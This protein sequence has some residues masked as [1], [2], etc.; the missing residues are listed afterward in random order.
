MRLKDYQERALNALDNWRRELK[1]MRGGVHDLADVAE[2]RGR[3][4]AEMRQ[5]LDFPELAWRSMAKRGELPGGIFR[6]SE[7]IV[8]PYSPRPNACGDP[9]P[10]VCLKIPTGGGKTFLG[11]K[12]LE[13][14]GAMTGVV[15]WVTPS[16]A[17]FQQTWNAFARRDH[18]YRQT[19]ERAS[20]G[21]V[22]LLKKDDSLHWVDVQTHLCVMPL[23][24]Q[25]SGGHRKDFLKIFRDAGRYPGFFPDRDDDE[26]NLAML[27]RHPDLQRDDLFGARAGMI[28]HSLFNALKIARPLIILDEAHNAYSAERRRQLCEFNPRMVLELSAT[29]DAGV[30]N[31]LVNISGEELRREQM[32][33][34]PLNVAVLQAADWKSALARAKEKRDEL[35]E[36]AKRLQEE[37]GRYIRPIMLI[38]VERVGKDQRDGIHIHAEDVRECLITQLNVP[39]EHIRRKTAEKD[40]IADEDLLSPYSPVRYIL[41]RNALQEGWDCPFA[42]VLSLL[43]TTRAARSLTQMTGRILRQPDAELTGVSALD[44]SYIYCHNRE[45]AETVAHVKSGLES[46]GMGDLGMFVHTDQRSGDHAVLS[47][48]TVTLGRRAEFRE[49]QVFLPRVLHRKERGKR[50]RSLDYD[51]DILGAI[52]WAKM[53]GT[54]T[55]DLTLGAVDKMRESIERVDLGDH[56]FNPGGR[57]YLLQADKSVSIS[58]F[59][60]LLGDVVPNPWVAAAI[61]RRTLES[62]RDKAGGDDGLFDRRY[63]LADA[64]K[65]QLAKVVDSEAENVFAA[66]LRDGD[67]RFEL[68]TDDNGFQLPSEISFM[69]SPD[70]P[71]LHREFGGSIQRS[72]YDGATLGGFNQLERAFALYADES[73]AVA[74]WHRMV[75]KQDYALQG[76]R[77]AKVYPDFVVCTGKQ[78]GERRILVLETKGMHLSENRDTQY[79]QTLMHRLEDSEPKALEC[80]DLVVKSGKNERRMALRIL[81]ADVWKDEFDKLAAGE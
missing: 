22:K 9:V 50:Y 80:G 70:A 7:K 62:L 30:S 47:G 72:L 66:K 48:K 13:R 4:G 37:T 32:I 61:V 53:A 14:M 1:Q 54:A 49:L 79:K 57:Q 35:E 67:I 73:E 11:V 2:E 25:A 38:R 33:K 78:G 3:D 77:R 31:I 5:I 17:I 10:H 41:T 55:L 51:S 74:W 12:A 29:P 15:L 43:D 59:T 40:E 28:R 6:Q 8:P 46:E 27:K 63:R 44:E 45:V 36:A 21:R 69:L 34:L 58:F 26:A 76:W 60:R 20:G 18:Y 52:D 39:L 23:M 71:I 64:M 81:L 75:A 68:T 56:K 19:L 65:L 16:R 42:Y 24:L